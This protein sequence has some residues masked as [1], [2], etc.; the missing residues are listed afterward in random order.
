MR[1]AHAVL[2]LACLA[3]PTAA[4]AQGNTGPAGN[5]EHD[6]RG[7]TPPE[8]VAPQPNRPA[9]PSGT[10]TQLTPQESQAHL[11]ALERVRA[12]QSGAAE[13]RVGDLELVSASG[14]RLGEVEDIML[15]A[16]G[17][18]AGYVIEAG[19]VL[20]IG[21]RELFVPRDAVRLERDANGRARL[22]TDQQI[23]SFQEASRRQ[24]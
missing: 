20:G 10:G 12:Q 18:L 8:M 16:E 11:E 15:D 6:S 23:G 3:M 5:P 2:V 24:R 9:A 7:Q 4:L 14:E 17:R 21:E 13:V 19:G 22:V 1:R